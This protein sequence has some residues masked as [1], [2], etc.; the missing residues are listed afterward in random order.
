MHLEEALRTFGQIGQVIA[1]L[2]HGTLD[3]QL[4]RAQAM[5]TNAQARLAAVRAEIEPNRIMAQAQ[6]DAARARLEQLTDPSQLDL[7]AA[8]R[9]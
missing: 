5:L 8:A 7:Q 9:W 4:Q 2:R 6:V 1:E 3:A